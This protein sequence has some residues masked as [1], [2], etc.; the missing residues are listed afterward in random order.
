M[1]FD[2]MTNSIAPARNRRRI[3]LAEYGVLLLILVAATALRLHGV[4]FGLPSLNDPD[5]PLFMMTALEM[6]RNHSL[7]PGWF[8]HPGTITLY[9]LALV[10]LAVGGIGIATGRF[11]DGPALVAAVYA[12]PGILFL[13]GR[14]FIVACGLLCVWFTWSLGGSSAGQG[15][16]SSRPPSSP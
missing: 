14:L 7:N 5:E 15:S 4:G 1:T 6:L 9:C 8:G 12:D 3:Q 10:S 2:S 16:D 11:A 13:P